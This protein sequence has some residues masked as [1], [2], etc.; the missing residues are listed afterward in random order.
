MNSSLTLQHK[1][2]NLFRYP[3]ALQHKSLQAW[4]AADEYLIEY[5]SDNIPPDR[6][7]NMLI[8]NDDFGALTCWFQSYQ[9]HWY[10]DS[11]VS[12]LACQMNL[13]DNGLNWDD[14]HFHDALSRPLAAEVIVLK[15]PKSQALLEQQLI[16]L[17]SV[18]TR[19]TQIIA[20]GKT[21]SI[22]KATLGLFE[23][24]LGTT[25]TSLA[26]KKARLI[27]CSASADK[28]H[29]SPYPTVWTMTD[30]GFTISNHANVFSRQSIDIGG[31]FMLENLPDCSGKTVVDLGCGNG[32]L[33]LTV[34]ARY[35]DA[36]VIFIDE[37]AMAIASAQQNVQ[38][39]LADS[40]ER[41]QFLLSNCLEQLTPQTI[42]VVL[43]NPPFHQQN[44][45]TDHIAWQMFNDSKQRL[46]RGGE[47]R[48]VGNRHLD[49]PRKLKK[50]FGGY[51]VV[52]SNQ[53]F[54]ILSCIKR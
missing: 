32:I 4:D 7:A 11:F 37:S 52:A 14:N 15:I 29:S 1:S 31:R 39:N 54:S 44:T 18:V 35:A 40:I 43:C 27:F 36:K 10:G 42:D 49:Y 19:Q 5:I 20:A 33:G 53:K 34:L 48:V 25:T 47:L 3:K 38:T 12:R 28:Q 41:A 23:K 26:R 8:F 2:L 17:Q 24:Y 21:N 16:D 22:S 9:P 6:L 46:V 45:I 50:L 13:R 51:Q 30:S